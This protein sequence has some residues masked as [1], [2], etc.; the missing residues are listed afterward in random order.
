MSAVTP[1]TNL[2]REYQ[3]PEGC[4]VVDK[5]GGVAKVRFDKDVF[6]V[7]FHDK[8]LLYSGIKA[9]CVFGGSQK[10]VFDSEEGIFKIEE[11]DAEGVHTSYVEEGEKYC[12]IYNYAPASFTDEK[13]QALIA[14]LKSEAPDFKPDLAAHNRHGLGLFGM[15]EKLIGYSFYWAR[16]GSDQLVPVQCENIGRFRDGGTSYAQGLFIKFNYEFKDQKCYLNGEP[17]T[18]ISLS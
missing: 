15:C 17:A 6:I 3:L 14:R 16:P 2:V 10:F 13:I 4:A 11:T 1:V 7:T 18:R 9:G 12:A 5:T 8:P